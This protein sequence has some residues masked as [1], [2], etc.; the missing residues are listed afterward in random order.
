M[1]TDQKI[2]VLYIKPRS[3]KKNTWLQTIH[4]LLYVH[5]EFSQKHINGRTHTHTHT[6]TDA[7]LAGEQEAL[8]V[9]LQ[10]MLDGPQLLCHDTE[11]RQLDPVELVETAPALAGNHNGCTQ[12]T[13]N[14]PLFEQISQSKKRVQMGG[15]RG[16]RT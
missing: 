8:Q 12:H 11:H 6:A 1:V 5:F 16:A 15:P 2:T 14:E 3:D 4:L 9:Q 10:R 13:G 7:C